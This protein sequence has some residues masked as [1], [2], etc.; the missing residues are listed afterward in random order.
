MAHRLTRGAELCVLSTTGSDSSVHSRVM[1][2]F[3]VAEDLTVWFGTS[4]TSRKV[5]DISR[6]PQGTATFQSR[7]GA[8]YVSV[9]GPL[10]VVGDRDA[11]RRRWRDDWVRFFPEGPDRGY[12]LLRMDVRRIEA[13]DFVHGLAPAP[14]GAVPAV[15]VR[16]DDRWVVA[17]DD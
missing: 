8:A 11:C 15:I 9:S 13:L 16:Q 3:P 14:Y 2:P 7:D 5:S 6:N 17:R 12:V 10:V 4:S 1:Q